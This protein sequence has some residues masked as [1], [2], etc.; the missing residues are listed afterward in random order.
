METVP[1]VGELKVLDRMAARRVA[2]E[3]AR[4][5]ARAV[6]RKLQEQRR[7]VRSAMNT[8]ADYHKIESMVGISGGVGGGGAHMNSNC[9]KTSTKGGANKDD[10]PVP[11][12]V[13]TRSP[14]R[15]GISRYLACSPEEEEKEA[16]EELHASIN[17][18]D[19]TLLS[20][21]VASLGVMLAQELLG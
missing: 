8:N 5:D 15:N 2:E 11:R 9:E 6:F 4:N 1:A 18:N 13:S 7:K 17:N 21:A 12:G 14:P 3:Q 10:D 19:R 20:P 16:D